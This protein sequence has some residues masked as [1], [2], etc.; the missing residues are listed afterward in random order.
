MQA[1]LV[2]EQESAAQGLELES[3]EPALVAELAQVLE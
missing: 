2:L 1:V 3:A